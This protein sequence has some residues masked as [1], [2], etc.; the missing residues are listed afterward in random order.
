[1][2]NNIQIAELQAK[3]KN[4]QIINNFKVEEFQV[5]LDANLINTVIRNL[6]S[7]AIKFTHLGGEIVLSYYVE[8]YMIIVSVKDNGVGLSKEAKEKIFYNNTEFIS[9]GT[10]NE[11]GTGL[12]LLICQD[13]INLH[14]GEIWV[15]SEIG[16]GSE[17]CF[18]LPLKHV[19]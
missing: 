8:D 12:G 4:I 11:K 18:S 15:N 16:K 17:F 19:D 5:I 10:N 13:F 2:K 14:K 9:E 1:M 7:N 3:D 6:L